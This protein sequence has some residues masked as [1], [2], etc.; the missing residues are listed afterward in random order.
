MSIHFGELAAR[1]AADGEIDAAELLALR[2]SGW[3]GDGTITLEEAAAVFAIQRAIRN[4]SPEW[5]DF[6]VE[7]IAEYVLNGTEPR[8][9]ADQAE[10][11]WLIAEIERD[12][13]VC[14][15]DELEL[16]VRIVERAQNVP[17]KLKSYVLET[18]ESA[19]L[20]GTG[21]TCDGGELSD[22]HVSE[23][24][25]TILR[26]T[27]FGA[28]SD[29]PAAV[30][31]REAE[32][33]FRLKDAT[34]DAANAPGWQR[35]FVQG[36]GNYLM[37]YASSTA[38]LDRERMLELEGFM[39]DTSTHVGRFMGRMAMAS[40]NAFGQVFGRKKPAGSSHD[41]LVAQEASL[42]PDER[43]WLNT[44]IEANG[45]VDAYDRALLD[46]LAEEN[47]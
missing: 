33:L 18:V 8:G 38:Q 23:A 34:L 17:E 20:T 10:A 29:R 25:V 19:V 47:A 12:G 14:S 46:F 39:N 37:A 3:G 35:L 32:M 22:S 40:P 2:R 15:M 42:T 31:R 41:D 11:E 44:R 36:V 16:L 9:Y 28:A 13:R 6:F 5:C 21:P 24:E 30:S 26:R 7:A 27:I 45:K 43:S 4:P 1:V